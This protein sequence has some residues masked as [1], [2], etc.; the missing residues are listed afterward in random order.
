[1]VR[2]LVIDPITP[3]TLY[4][5]TNNAEN[6]LLGGVY[7]S[8]DGGSNW[9]AS[10]TGLNTSYVIPE[11]RAMVIDPLTPSTLYVGTAVS[12]GGDIYVGTD[13]GGVYKSMDG[14]DSWT[15]INN[16]LPTF[17]SDGKTHIYDIYTLAIDPLTPSTLY[18][19]TNI[20]GVYKSMDGGDSWTAINNGLP[21]FQLDGK[22]HIYDIYT[23]AIDPLTPS[24]L[25]AGTVGV[26]VYKSTDAG[27]NWT[28]MNDGLPTYGNGYY[29]SIDSLIIDPLTPST[30][31]AY[32]EVQGVF[33]STDGGISWN[34][35]N[36]GLPTYRSDGKTYLF[37]ALSIDPLT[38]STLYTSV[39]DHMIFKS[40]DA[41]SSW[42]SSNTGLP[43]IRF[44]PWP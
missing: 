39:R 43:G 30:L 29:G 40:T 32:V 36:S 17:Q 38:P 16:G 41:G 35:I 18:A 5:G 2:V 31:Y 37:D 28:A 7:K 25:Y 8:T 42:I 1:M 22:T 12:G 19:G 34:A 24:T 9:T 11:I 21:T 4:A 3:S 33:K 27:R 26:G 6:T 44:T 15:A 23:L 10:N 20:V 13:A 14:G